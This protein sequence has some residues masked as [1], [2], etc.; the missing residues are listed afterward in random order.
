MLSLMN[1]RTRNPEG[2]NPNRSRGWRLSA[3]LT[4]AFFAAG[5]EATPAA[6][7]DPAGAGSP[8][9]QVYEVPVESPLH[10]VPPAPAD[11]RTVAVDPAL[12]AASPFG[13]HDTDGLSGPEFTTTQGNNVHAYTDT[14]ANNI[15]DPASSPDGTAALLFHF[16]LDL[17]LPPAAYRP[18]SVTELFYWNN[19]VHDLFHGFGFDEAGGNFQENNYGNGGLGSDSVQAEAQDGSGTNG[20]NFATPPDGGNPRLQLMLGTIPNPDVDGVFDNLVV[21]HEIG[22]G[23]ATRLAGGPGNS[24]C[25]ANAEQ[26]GEGWSDYFGLFLTHE[27]GDTATTPRIIGAYFFGGGL[28]G[29]GIRLAPYTT[30]FATNAYTYG[31]LPTVAIPHGVGFVW[32]TALW[33]VYWALIAQHGFNPDLSG[34]WTTGGNNLALQLVLDGLKLQ[35]CSPGFVDGRNAILAADTVLTG[36]ANQCR[37]WEAFARRGLGVSAAQGSANSILDGTEAFDVPASCSFGDA[38]ADA[39]VCAAAGEHHQDFTVGPGYGSPPVDLAASGHPPGASLLWSEDPVATV[40]AAVTLTVGNLGAVAPGIYD[41]T[42]TGDDGVDQRSDSFALTVDAAPAAPTVL[43]LPADGATGVATSAPLAW[44]AVPGV[45]TYDVEV[46]D[47]ADFSS[48]ELAATVA[49]SATIATG[50][51]GDTLYSWRVRARNGCGGSFTV[52]RTFR[53]ALEFCATPALAIPDGPAPAVT[54]TIVVPSGPATLADLDVRLIATH[55]W[56]GDLTFTLAHGGAP[57]V[58]FDRPGRTVSGF[59]CSGDDVAVLANDEGPDGTI[60]AQCA[61]LPAISGNRIGGDPASSS[62]LAAFDGAALAGTWTLTAEDAA[63]GATGTLVEWCLLPTLAV[64]PLV[65]ADGFESGTTGLWSS[66]LP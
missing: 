31:D 26:M 56:V 59:G 29:P 36:G 22:H 49:G 34:D 37:L 5:L 38:G 17:S 39:R 53:T 28:A 63:A 10:S 65:F 7:G 4:L 9:Y 44:T 1:R 40:P 12:A 46:D 41:V 20:G 15:P 13:W 8:S 33:E 24:S 25:L 14:D 6:P 58:L 64:D 45:A 60:E 61:N 27:A 52:A 30:D 55:T 19:I 16:P 11:G 32:A 51:A 2:A 18:A 57:V 54:S 62:L 23:I 3:P 48:P 43:A 47:D 66:V 50:L 35:P 21:A 42:I